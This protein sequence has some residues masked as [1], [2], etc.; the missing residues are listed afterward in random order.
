MEP[1][2]SISAAPHGPAKTFFSKCPDKIKHIRQTVGGLTNS[3]PAPGGETS[4]ALASKHAASSSKSPHPTHFPQVVGHG[5]SPIIIIISLLTRC[6]KQ[7]ARFR[8]WGS[9]SFGKRVVRRGVLGGKERATPTT[10]IAQLGRDLTVCYLLRS[11]AH[12]R[13]NN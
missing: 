2:C 12:K 7:S 5:S 8:E 3:Q 13:R 10:R 11:T 4:A 9:G 1:V 6:P